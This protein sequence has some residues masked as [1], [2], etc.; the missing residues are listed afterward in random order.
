LSYDKVEFYS[1]PELNL[2]EATRYGFSMAQTEW[3]AVIDSDV[4]L[5]KGWFENMKKYMD[6]ADAVE[7]CRVDH[8]VF[9]VRTD[10]T[11][12]TYGRFGQTL[13]KREPVM[14]MDLNIQY[15][16]DTA[17]KFN[18]DKEGKKWK[19]VGNYL[20]DHYT[21]LEDTTHYRTGLV[22][23]PEPQVIYIP[24]NVQIQQGHVNRKY[25]AITKKQA[26][27][28]LLLPP[29]YEAYWSFKRNF[30]FTLAY[31]KLT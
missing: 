15:G 18:F 24:K 11:K 3:V 14:H 27:K 13:L 6:E 8:H 26:I 2:G 16:E 1:K 21:K 10:I 20:A 5:R 30:W 9:T 17:T 19:K 28:R 4:I 29:I 12:S 31:F 23:T 22:F 25:R 7:G